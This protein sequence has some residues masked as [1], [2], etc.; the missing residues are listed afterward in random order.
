ML[1]STLRRVA[2]TALTTLLWC[3]GFGVLLEDAI[4]VR[5]NRQ[6]R[7]VM[8]TPPEIPVGR[9]LRD[10]AAVSLNGKIEQISL[11]SSDSERLLIVTFSPGCPACREN[12][13]GWLALTAQLKSHPGWRVLWISR[14][15]IGITADEVGRQGISSIEILADPPYRT[16]LQLAMGA[17][18]KTIVVGTDGTVQRVWQGRL[19]NDD[20]K[21]IAAY[22]YGPPISRPSRSMPS[23]R[24][25]LN[26]M[27][28]EAGRATAW[29][30]HQGRLGSPAHRFPCFTEVGGG[31]GEAPMAYL[32]AVNSEE[33]V[34]SW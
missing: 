7:A 15:P 30:G 11:P 26:L 12:F 21:Q 34:L 22:F 32:L 14:D 33:E 25:S 20:W 24:V 3:A 23:P 10:L 28:A 2:S 16:Y 5:Q 19:Q 18:P 9:Q 13:R 29:E 8:S 31:F 17:V 27:L 1:N 6:L 4:L